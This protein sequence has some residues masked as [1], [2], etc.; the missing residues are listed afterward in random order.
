MIT[1]IADYI[2]EFC[3][4]PGNGD[5][6]NDW[7]FVLSLQSHICPEC[8][9]KAENQ[10]NKFSIV[11]ALSGVWANMEDPREDNRIEEL[12]QSAINLYGARVYTD[13]GYIIPS[14]HKDKIYDLGAKALKMKEKER[15]NDE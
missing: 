5:I 12:L 15:M 7:G 13:D 3:Y 4:K 6:P 14:S 9:S 10:G 1:I 11:S 2:C 8:L